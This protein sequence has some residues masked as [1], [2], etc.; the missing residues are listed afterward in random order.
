[1]RLWLDGCPTPIGE[2]LIAWDVYGTLRAF[3][4]AEFE[5]RMLKLLHRHYTEYTLERDQAPAS[6][7]EPIRQYFAGD[8]AALDPIAVATGGTDFQKSVWASLREIKAGETTSYGALAR[9]VGRERSYRAVGKANNE[10]PIAIVVPCHRVIGQNGD[11]VGYGGG[12]PRKRWLL[13]H[14]ARSVLANL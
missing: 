6:L 11:L 2:M 8:L 7:F 13:A 14:E 1:M 12:L 10:N 5:P 4:F 9:R 3:D